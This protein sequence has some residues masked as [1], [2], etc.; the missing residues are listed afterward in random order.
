MAVSAKKTFAK[1]I[2]K[3]TTIKNIHTTPV[4]S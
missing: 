1:I 3:K 2:K 4:E